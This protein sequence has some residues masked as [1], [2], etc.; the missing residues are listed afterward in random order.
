MTFFYKYFKVHA[1]SAPLPKFKWSF[2]RHL[3]AN[4]LPTHSCQ[5]QKEG[6]QSS[7][8]LKGGRGRGGGKRE[9]G[10]KKGG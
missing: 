2:A 6:L 7:W 3:S 8:G 9:G 10:G 5:V 1:H 4:F